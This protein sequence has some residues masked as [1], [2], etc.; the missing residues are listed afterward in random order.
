MGILDDLTPPLRVYPCKVAQIKADLDAADQQALE[1][2]IHN[3]AWTINALEAALLKKGIKLT[4]SVLLNHRN[5]TCSCS[6]I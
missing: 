4:R 3:T 6:K 1:V 5:E 2:A